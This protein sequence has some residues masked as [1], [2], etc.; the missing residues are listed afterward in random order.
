VRSE[1]VESFGMSDYVSVQPVGPVPDVFVFRADGQQ[2]R[3]LRGPATPVTIGK[4]GIDV[5]GRSFALAQVALP[6]ANWMSV[7]EA[8][9]LERHLESLGF[10]GYAYA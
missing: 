10:R 1:D 4:S 7:V 2:T 9:D 3:Y 6:G 5:G 8:A